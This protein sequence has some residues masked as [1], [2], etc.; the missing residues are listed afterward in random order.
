MACELRQRKYLN[1]LIEQDH[2]FIK[3][4]VKPGMGFFSFETGWNTFQGYGSMNMLRKGQV[5]GGEKGNVTGQIEFIGSLFGLV[6]SAR[7]DGD[8]V[9]ITFPCESLQHS[10]YRRMHIASSCIPPFRMLR[11]KRSAT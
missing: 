1:N 3:R 4:L 2:R 5:Y 8:F 7:D 10:R 11:G 6:A 9:P